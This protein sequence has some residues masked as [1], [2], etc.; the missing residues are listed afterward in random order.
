MP[1]VPVGGRLVLVPV[2]GWRAEPGGRLRQ[3]G[4]VSSAVMRI[5]L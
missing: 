2:E 3:A 4:V 1:V 5:R